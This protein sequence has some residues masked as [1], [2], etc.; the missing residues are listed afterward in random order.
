[1]VRHGQTVEVRKL[2]DSGMAT[3]MSAV[4]ILGLAFLLVGVLAAQQKPVQYR[5]RSH[6]ARGPG[7]SQMRTRRHRMHPVRG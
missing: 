3:K 2:E 5:H 4:V 7:R 6:P 1:M